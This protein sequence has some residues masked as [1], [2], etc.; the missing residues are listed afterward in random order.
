MAVKASRYLTHIL[1]LR[2]PREP[3]ARFVDRVRGLGNKL[4]PALLQLPPT[5]EADLPRL[6]EVLERFPPDIQVAVEFRHASWFT[7][8]T[9]RVLERHRAALCLADRYGPIAPLWR[10]ADWGYARFHQGRATP[11][12]CYGTGALDTWAKRLGAMFEPEVPLYAYFNN[13]H[14]ACAIRNAVEFARAC[15]VAGLGPTRAEEA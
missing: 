4:G 15:E 6:T 9:R 1:R 3:V 10:T 7:D 5:L 2:E 8:E 11:R 12:P 13:D 14:R